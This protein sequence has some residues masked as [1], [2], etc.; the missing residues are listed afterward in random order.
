MRTTTV[1]TKLALALLASI[2]SVAIV[3]VAFAAVAVAQDDEA[4][5]LFEDGT[6]LYE[7]GQ[8]AEAEDRFRRSLELRP[9]S[10]VRYNLAAVLVD[11]GR[12]AEARELYAIVADDARAPAEVRRTAGERA[13]ELEGRLARLTVTLEGEPEGVEVRV[14]GEAIDGTGPHLVDPGR[15]VLLATR[16]GVRVFRR[17]LTLGEGE[18]HAV[19]VLTTVPDVVPAEPPP[20]AAPAS[21]DV[22]GEWWLWTLVGLAVAALTAGAVAIGVVLDEGRYFS[23]N[24]PPGRIVVE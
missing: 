20:A 14:D 12:F 24:V 18:R 15:H 16:D 23:G 5:A 21:G 9:A 19:T 17:E 10:S 4:R 13:S 7:R 3:T 1:K 6:E 22:T 8:L 2:M 11:T